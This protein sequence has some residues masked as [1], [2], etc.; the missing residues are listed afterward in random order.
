MTIKYFDRKTGEII[1]EAPPAEKLLKFLYHNP[2][3]KSTILSLA[4]KK[5]ISDYYG[6]QMNKSTSISKIQDFIDT[7]NIDMSEVQKDIKDFSCF[8]D[9]FYRKLK[10]SARPIASNFVSPGDGRLLAFES[11]EGINKFYV[12]GR[13]FTLYEFLQDKK[14]AERFSN[15]SLLL[16]RLAPNDY[17]RYHFPIAG[18]AS[19]SKRIEGS[20]FSVSPLALVNNFAK[21][22]CE[23]K[24]EYCIL[25]T[26][27]KGDILIAP[28]GATMVGS[29][30]CSY[31]ADTTVK[32][33][34][35]MGYFAFG[36]SSIVLLVNKDRITIDS[37]I[38]E[39]SAN[40]METYVR[41]GEK[42][43]E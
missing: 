38:L 10:K 27:E 26:K 6:K 14:L 12:K 36:G 33:G 23:N 29:I 37:D 19:E 35:E 43:A 1:T 11:F 21:V 18:T 3:G 15:S 32:K 25:N 7:Y 13:D 4:K 41:F 22:F 9:F 42:I 39:N 30:Y 34:Q 5:F 20:Y 17:H 31:T 40:G 16:L 2:L 28:V 24:R 8:N